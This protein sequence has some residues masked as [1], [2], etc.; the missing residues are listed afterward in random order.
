[1]GV[2][3]STL[4]T[5]F[6]ELVLRIFAFVLSKESSDNYILFLSRVSLAME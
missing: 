3:H 4:E 5:I 2:K 1:M 6:T